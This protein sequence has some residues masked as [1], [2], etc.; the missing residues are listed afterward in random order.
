MKRAPYSSNVIETP[1]IY[2]IAGTWVLVFAGRRAWDVARA[3]VEDGRDEEARARHTLVAPPGREPG[4]FF[5]PVAQRRACICDTGGCDTKPLI[6]ALVRCRASKVAVLEI[7]LESS[8]WVQR[9]PAQPDPLQ[10]DLALVQ[11]LEA[12]EVRAEREQCESFMALATRCG[13]DALWQAARA[14]R[15]SAG[16]REH[17]PR[18]IH[19]MYQ[20]LQ[21][22]PRA[23]ARK[24]RA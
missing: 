5:W 15:D 19:G 23:R 4:E 18:R 17:W 21:L 8:W 12:T 3:Y 10:F 1:A 16:E 7:D 14:V 20:R 22:A 24:R 6:E 9:L 11:R 13:D 2:W